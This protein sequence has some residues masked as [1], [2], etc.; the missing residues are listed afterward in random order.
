MTQAVTANTT[1]KSLFDI[2]DE[3]K[4]EEGVV[5]RSVVDLRT[6]EWKPATS[7]I[8]SEAGQSQLTYQGVEYTLNRLS[9]EQLCKQIVSGMHSLCKKSPDSLNTDIFKAWLPLTEEKKANVVLKMSEGSKSVKGIL[10]LDR[11]DID[12]STIIKYFA[13]ALEGFNYSVE[14]IANDPDGEWFW[15]R[16]IL[17]DLKSTAISGVGEYKLA[18]DFRCSDYAVSKLEIDIGMVCE[19]TGSTIIGRIDGKPY[20]S[21]NYKGIDGKDLEEA[22]KS[23]AKR[24]PEQLKNAEDALQRAL[25]STV[26][27]GLRQQLIRQLPRDRDTSK[28]VMVKVAGEIDR[29]NP[30]TMLS[31]ANLVSS[32]AATLDSPHDRMKHEAFAGYLM[33][34]VPSTA[35]V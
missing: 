10:G 26:D 34:F 14:E 18:V 12:S 7:Q 3:R 11:S 2:Y 32:V 31:V 1:N 16:I 33:G 23:A 29:H 22:I 4:R 27:S 20:F 21:N 24:F 19:Q 9:F 35:K 15:Y 8:A 28:A 25:K 5:Q 30:A 17:H 13:E 6:C